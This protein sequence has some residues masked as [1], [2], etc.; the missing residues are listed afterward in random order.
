MTAVALRES[1]GDP[2]AFNGKPP[3]KSYGLL[4]I[5]MIGD[6]SAQRLKLFGITGENELFDPV[7]N[8]RAGWILSGG[9]AATPVQR[10]MLIRTAWAI[11]R[12]D[13][14]KTPDGYQLAFAKHLPAAQLAA[15]MV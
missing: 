13:W 11:Y 12:K 8:A 9:P 7:I 2:G 3:D 10:I 6:L 14:D 4:Q 15:I 5:N 1:F